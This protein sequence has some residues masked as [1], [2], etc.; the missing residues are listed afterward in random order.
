MGILF[1]IISTRQ[2]KNTTT[3]IAFTATREL[4]PSGHKIKLIMDTD[5]PYALNADNKHVPKDFYYYL[6][7]G[8]D[9]LDNRKPLYNMK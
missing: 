4:I 6:K 7:T 8:N 5:N 2:T 3:T 9:L 1:F